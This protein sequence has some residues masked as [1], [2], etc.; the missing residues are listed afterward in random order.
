MTTQ[1]SARTKGSQF[2]LECRDSLLPVFHD[3]QRYGGEGFVS[4][5]DLV[6]RE[7]KV[8]VECKRW[9]DLGVNHWTKLCELYAKLVEKS[10]TMNYAPDEFYL[11]FKPN[12][13]PCLVMFMD[14]DFQFTVKEFTTHFGVPFLDRK[15]KVK[16]NDI[17]L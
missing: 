6:S 9:K 1:R 4:Q 2:E 11:L 15:K 3:I 12:R 7:H 8:A 16:T 13:S 5:V 14:A 10:S 17:E